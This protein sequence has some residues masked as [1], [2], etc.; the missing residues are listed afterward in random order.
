MND[1][2]TT[3]LESKRIERRRLAA[4]PFTEKVPILEKLRDRALSIA[5][6]SLRKNASSGMVVQQRI[7]TRPSFT[8]Q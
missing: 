7:L 4:L 1:Q 3:I 6:S 5:N 8:H 2:I